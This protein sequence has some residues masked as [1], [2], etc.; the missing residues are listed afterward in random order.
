MPSLWQEVRERSTKAGRLFA[1]V[2]RLTTNGPCKEEYVK[3]GTMERC[4]P[5]RLRPS[6]KSSNGLINHFFLQGF[7]VTQPDSGR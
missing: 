5:A 1:L 2:R 4:R 6:D 7:Y 3:R